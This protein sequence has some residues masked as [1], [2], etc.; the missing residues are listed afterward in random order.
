MSKKVIQKR[1]A[2]YELEPDGFS[3]HTFELSMKLSGYQMTM[4]ANALYGKQKQ[5]PPKKAWMYPSKDNIHVCTLY[6]KQGIGRI[7]FIDNRKSSEKDFCYLYMVINPRLLVEPGTSY[8]GILPPTKE[9]IKEIERAFSKLFEKSPFESNINAYQLRRV[10]LCTNLH[11]GHKKIFRETVRV[12][13]KLPTPSKYKRQGSELKDKKEARNMD[14]HYLHF[15]CDF[16]DLVIYDK[17]YQLVEN[18]L[19]MAHEEI[20]DGVLR[21]EVQYQREYIRRT[22][23]TTGYDRTTDLLWHFMKN[24]EALLCKNFTQNFPD[25]TFCRM[26]EIETRVA[27]SNFKKNAKAAMLRLAQLLQRKQSVD[28]ALKELEKEGVSTGGLLDR[29]TELGISPIPLWQNFCAKQIPGPVELLRDRS[30]GEI[31]IAY[32]K[33]KFK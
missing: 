4:I 8:R 14:K 30:A 12:L 22:E 21:F 20:P 24:S 15:G 28:K 11:C 18:G 23:K 7:T 19:V 3:I 6:K 31:S 17:S 25:V 16:K 26:D 10:D 1:T 13:R 33:I 5:E 2:V 32:E 27:E 9:S 29:F